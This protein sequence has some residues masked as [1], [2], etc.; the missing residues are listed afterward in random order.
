MPTTLP[1]ELRFVDCCNSQLLAVDYI[2]LA[3]SAG[4]I[5]CLCT[6]QK[7]KN[8]LEPLCFGSGASPHYQNIRGFLVFVLY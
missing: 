8:P 2:R 1:I 3:R 7:S 5:L 4:Y 6:G